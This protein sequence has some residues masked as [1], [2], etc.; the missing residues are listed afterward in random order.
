MVISMSLLASMAG[1]AWLGSPWP[2]MQV[3]HSSSRWLELPEPVAVELLPFAVLPL[4][5]L[6][7][8][9]RPAPCGVL[10]PPLQAASPMAAAA[11]RIASPAGRRYVVVMSRL[12]A[13]S[14]GIGTPG[15][16]RLAPVRRGVAAGPCFAPGRSQ[17]D[18]AGLRL[19]RQLPL[20]RQN[21]AGE[22]DLAESGRDGHGEP[23]QVLRG[24]RE[25][26]DVRCLPGARRAG[27]WADSHAQ[28]QVGARADPDGL[29]GQAVRAAR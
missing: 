28:R 15:R 22:R 25:P 3:A 14:S 19:G 4:A 7:L 27:G 23:G 26:G 9:P 21:G 16:S 17:A 24:R 6:L 12:L 13:G 18:H 2:R 8:F 1:S 20:D 29:G 11:T 5:P 10:D